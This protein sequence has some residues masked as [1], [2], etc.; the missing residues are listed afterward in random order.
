MK[1]F[2]VIILAWVL[3]SCESNWGKF[4]GYKI[5]YENAL[6]Y[7]IVL[8]KVDTILENHPYYNKGTFVKYYRNHFIVDTVFIADGG[9]V[10]GSFVDVN[11]TSYDNTFILVAQKPLDCICECNNSCLKNKYIKTND[12]PTYKMC[13]EA[14]EKSIFYQFWIINKTIDAVYG[15]Y[16][17]E[18][19]LYERKELGV[20][21]ELKLDFEK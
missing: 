5:D 6:E 15:P 21:N 4:G 12:L 19:Y 10:I 16:N 17:M 7:Y 18:E 9:Y 11:K 3:F 1:Y 13:K 8:D 14:L 2:L 20:P